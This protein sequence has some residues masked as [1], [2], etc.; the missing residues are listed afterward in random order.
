MTQINLSIEK[1]L[2]GLEHRLV[3]AKGEGEGEGQTGNLG[4]L[5]TNYC[6]WNG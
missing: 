3:F 6:I 2:M 1:K 4:L 5:G